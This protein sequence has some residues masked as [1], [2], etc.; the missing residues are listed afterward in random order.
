MGLIIQT[1]IQK[2]EIKLI[3]NLKVVKVEW[4]QDT[5]FCDEFNNA[6]WMMY[7]KWKIRPSIEFVD[8]YPQ[9]TT[10]HYHY[11]GSSNM[12]VFPYHWEHDLPPEKLDQLSQSYVESRIVKTVKNSTYSTEFQMMKQRGLFF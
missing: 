12:K 7:H 8:E 6:E 10:F 11:E 9:V 4:Y 2:Y 1:H 5:Y 3:D